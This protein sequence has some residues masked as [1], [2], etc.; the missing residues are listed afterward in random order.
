MT[1]VTQCEEGGTWRAPGAWVK[2]MASSWRAV[3][4]AAALLLFV[5]ALGLELTT[6]RLFGNGDGAHPRTLAPHAAGTKLP[7]AAQG[8]VSRVLGRDDP[9]YRVAGTGT[10][11]ALRNPSHKLSARFERRGIVIRSGRGTLGL[12]LSAYG[13]GRAL[14]AV[15]AVTPRAR[16]NRVLYRRPAL[17]EWYAN[18][19]F[20][21]EQ[22]FTVAARPASGHSGLLT[23]ALALSGNL[24]AALSHGGVTFSR[25]GTSLVYQ[26]LIATDARGRRLPARI[27]LRRRAVLLRVDDRGA[28]YPLRVDPFVQAAKLTASDGTDGDG[29]GVSLAVSGDGSTVIASALFATVGHSG[30]GPGAVYVFVKPAGG[31]TSGTETAKLTASDAARADQLGNSVSVSDDGSTVIAGAPGAKTGEPFRGQGAAYVFVKPAGG[32][33]SGTETAKLTASDPAPDDNLGNSVAVSGDGATVIAGAPLATTGHPFEGPGAVYVFVKR[34]G[35]WASGTQTAKLT[36]SDG[37]AGVELGWSVAVSSDGATVI[38]GAP[39]ALLS[40]TYPGAA[41]VFARPAGG[42]AN[43][44]E[45]AKLTASDGAQ[46]DELGYSVAVSGDGATVIAGAPFAKVGANSYQ[47]AAFVFARPAGGWANGTEKAKLTASDGAVA[48]QLG[49]SVAVSGDGATVIA[50]APFATFGHPFSGPGAAYVFTAAKHPTSTGVSCSPSPVVAGNST[51][52]TATVTDTASSGQT[53]PRGTVTFSSNGP[54]SFGNGGTC[55]LVA[56]SSSSASCSATYKPGST[57]SNPVRTDTIMATYNGDSTHETSSGSTDVEVISPTALARGS[58]VIGDHNATVGTVVTFWSAQWSKLNS[59]SGGPAPAGFDGFASHAPSN[60]PKCGD[61]WTTE[62][63][64]SS[65][66]PASVPQY[67]EVIASSSI[68]KAGSTIAG[69]APEVVVVKTNPGYGPDP[70]SAGTGAVV[71]VVC[72]S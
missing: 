60:P 10:G 39:S 66:P 61:E 19:P 41:Y 27:E 46:G 72:H 2:T 70:G 31:W 40:G 13:H 26:G 71:A 12:S 29:L 52:C 36:A 4:L 34:A 69:N 43:G 59:L 48:D 64:N 45:K 58:F 1:A 20:G 44:T 11:L 33:A 35:G 15:G 28:R 47:G 14:H 6:P 22:G 38:A 9:S 51:T 56:A 55:T 65:D 62:P 8:P 42:W 5:A 7:L 54:G 49:N 24:R 18:G 63:G 16:A 57:P 21:L 3:V 23:L 53:A 67:M 68:T 32:W 50:G 17:D 30:V 37:V 25:P